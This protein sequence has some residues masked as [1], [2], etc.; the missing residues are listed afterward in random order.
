MCSGGADIPLRISGY[1]IR[2]SP[3]QR[4]LAPHRGSFVACHA[5]NR[6]SV[7]R[8]P[9]CALR[10]LAVQR[11]SSTQIAWV[12]QATLTLLC[13]YVVV[14]VQVETLRLASRRDCSSRECSHFH[15]CTPEPTIV[16]A[17]RRCCRICRCFRIRRMVETTGIEPVTPCVQGR[18][19]PS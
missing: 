5:L 12:L 18:C 4:L 2:G 8:H 9:S 15:N 13:L 11:E 6:L 19:S 14:N 17:A 10:S 1:P 3:G 16:Q 7:P